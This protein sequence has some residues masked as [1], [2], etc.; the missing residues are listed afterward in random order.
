MIVAAAGGVENFLLD[1]V[2]RR[3]RVKRD[4]RAAERD[5]ETRAD[6]STSRRMRGHFVQPHLDRLPGDMP[7]DVRGICVDAER[8]RAVDPERCTVP[9][10]LGSGTRGPLALR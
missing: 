3:C 6:E 9:V 10:A 1:P 2:A 7:V 4:V 5:R 8:A